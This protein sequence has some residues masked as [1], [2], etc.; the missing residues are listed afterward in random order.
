MF[1]VTKREFKILRS[2]F[3]I[4]K[5]GSGGSRYLPF[6]F[7]EQGVARLSSVVNTK[8][9]IQVNIAIMRAFVFIRQYALSHRDLTEK[10]KELE[11]KYSKQFKD[12][13]EAINYLLQKDKLE[14]AQRKRKKIGFRQNE[15]A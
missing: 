8:K 7:T 5:L 2:Q 15:E 1:E 14:V 12:V 3:V 13:Y 11:T 4:S 6:A 10:L 9:T